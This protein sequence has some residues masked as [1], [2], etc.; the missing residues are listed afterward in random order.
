M[1]GT[2]VK[3]VRRQLELRFLWFILGVNG[4]DVVERSP[5][6]RGLSSVLKSKKAPW[7]PA[8]LLTVAEVEKFHA[9]LHDE[10]KPLG[11]RIISG[12]LLHLL[13]S[14]ARW[15]DMLA[16]MNWHIDC[17]E[18]YLQVDIKIHKGS[19]NADT[20]SKLL[21][22]VAPCTGVV[23]A[24]WATKY[25]EL[26]RAAGLSMPADRSQ[27][28][29]PA[30]MSEHATCWTSR[31][32]ES[33]EGSRFMREL[34]G[35]PRTVDRRVSTHSLKSTA[36]SWASK[37]GLT[38]YSRSVL[39]RH[40]A[41]VSTATAVYSREL[42][43]PVLREFDT[44]LEGIRSG[45]CKPACDEAAKEEQ[46]VCQWSDAHFRPSPV[47]IDLEESASETTESDSEQSTSSS[48]SIT[49]A[50]GEMHVSI[51][52]HPVQTWYTNRSSLVVHRL[53]EGQTLR[54][55]RKVTDS[56]DKVISSHGIRCSRCFD[57]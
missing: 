31:H 3:Q 30:P 42:L 24:N 20:K 17:L 55:G 54:C 41:T 36:I 46:E 48:D 2:C 29:L 45:A 8:D 13:Y 34:L 14:R 40:T 38:E 35:A 1:S 39:A 51:F 6:I 21:P 43:S 5:R 22:I 9:I 26:R 18:K 23:H 15:S 19:R 27:A 16:V 33:S 10:S 57:T 53:R 50:E 28:L 11:D 44:V 49:E 12:H 47:C 52:E 7:R 56:Y 32:M 37:Y 4:A 25:A